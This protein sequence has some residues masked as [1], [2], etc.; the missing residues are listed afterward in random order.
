MLKKRV[1]ES[2]MFQ[3]TY[4]RHLL[5]DLIPQPEPPP[6]YYSFMKELNHIG[7]NLNQVAQKAHIL[8]VIDVGRYDAVVNQLI[9]SLNRIE[10]A[11]LL[12][13]KRE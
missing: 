3:E 9:E 7:N 11:V 8:N 1:A 5:N 6:D 2:G 4:I 13:K 12:P 10:V